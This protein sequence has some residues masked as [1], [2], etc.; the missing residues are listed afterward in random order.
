MTA[1]MSGPGP[2]ARASALEGLVVNRSATP[3]VLRRLMALPDFP[4]EIAWSSPRI[5]TGLADVLLGL[6]D[7]GVDEALAMNETLPAD[8]LGRL[9]R[10]PSPDVRRHVPRAGLGADVVDV[11]DVEELLVHDADAGVRAAVARHTE[12]HALAALLADDPDATVREALASRA[13]TLPRELVGRLLTDDAPAV[14]AAVLR[15]G[16][17]T[18]PRELRDRLLADPAT[19]ALTV[20]HLTPAPD[21]ALRLAADPDPEVRAALAGCPA[22]PEEVQALL[23]ADRDGLVRYDVLFSRW[24]PDERR[25]RH[26]ARIEEDDRA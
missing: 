15:P 25:M 7:P 3:G 21:L 8:V 17:A 26:L 9:A 18:P 19:R 1:H 14:R 22:L 5:D 10:H 4:E 16:G 6:A 23:E 20:P 24:L 13:G 12:R 2:G 11:E